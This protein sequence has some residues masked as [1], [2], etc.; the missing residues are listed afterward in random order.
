MHVTCASTYSMH[1]CMHVPMRAC[2]YVCLCMHVCKHDCVCGTLAY[3]LACMDARHTCVRACLTTYSAKIQPHT[4]TC[5]HVNEPLYVHIC[6]PAHNGKSVENE[7]ILGYCVKRYGLHTK[8]Y[9]HACTRISRHKRLLHPA[10]LH[11]G[12]IPCVGGHL[13]PEF[14]RL[15]Q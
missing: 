9:S 8:T 15:S 2:M 6:P 5:L 3:S 7:A 13:E 10:N 4:T 12:G 1:A 14:L 11:R